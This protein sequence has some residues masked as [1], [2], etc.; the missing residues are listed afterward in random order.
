MP[1]F[2]LL[3]S[4]AKRLIVNPIFLIVMLCSLCFSMGWIYRGKSIE[5][6]QLEAE[7]SAVQQME[8][9]REKIHHRYSAIKLDTKSNLERVLSFTICENCSSTNAEVQPDNH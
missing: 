4:W 5:K 8:V 9:K 7:L 6:R 2:L 3:I 1:M